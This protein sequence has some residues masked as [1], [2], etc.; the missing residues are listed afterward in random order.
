MFIRQ[1]FYLCLALMPLLLTSCFEIIE[2]VTLNKD[3]SGQMKLT[4]NLSQSS[5]KLSAIMMMD[6]IQGY[7]VPD[8]AGITEQLQEAADWLRTQKGIGDVNQSVNF[9]DYIAVISFSFR[10]VNDI[11]HLPQKLLEQY[12][13]KTKLSATYAYDPDHAKFA[14]RYT[15]SNEVKE[16]FSR[17]KER[18]REVLKAASYVS[19]FRFEKSINSFSNKGAK[20]S[21]NQ[22]AIMQRFPL[23][24]LI[25]GK[26]DISNEIHLSK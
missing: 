8:R 20:L 11:N 3:G 9:N 6:S 13:V 25:S 2:D 24:D 21:K 1:A 19:I 10:N 17:L 22:Q 16:Q 26:A 14:R 15:Y 5:T 7:K 23:S 12:K 4:L 18:D